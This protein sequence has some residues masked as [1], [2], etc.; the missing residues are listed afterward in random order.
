MTFSSTTTT[1]ASV[2]PKADI[3]VHQAGTKT[4]AIRRLMELRPDLLLRYQAVLFL[5]DD[6]GIGAEEIDAF[7]RAMTDEKLDLA[8][9]A[10]TAD[11][12]T[13]YPFLKRPSAGSGVMRVSSVEIMAPAL[14]RRALESANWAFAESVS[15]WGSDL[16]LGPAVREA[17]GQSERRGHRLGRRPAPGACRPRC[18]GLLR[19]SASLRRGSRTRGQ[20]GRG[21]LR[22]R[23]LSQAPCAGRSRRNLPSADWE[24]NGLII[25]KTVG[26]TIANIPAQGSTGRARR[27]R[28]DKG[29]VSSILIAWRA[30]RRKC[31]GRTRPDFTH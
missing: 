20:Q 25:R 13:A 27:H 8:Q 29:G 16:I 19:I 30:A 12:A 9:P 17:F 22:R 28:L 2:H 18:R 21:R 5:D 7:F 3:A 10:L 24:R 4:T 31:E 26:R 14:T 11:S 6:V 15:G 1:R 23:T